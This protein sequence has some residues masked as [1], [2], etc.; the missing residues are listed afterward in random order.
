MSNSEWDF[1]SYWDPDMLDDYG[2]TVR[3]EA[4]PGDF[5]PDV[6]AT[7]ADYEAEDTSYTDLLDGLPAGYGVLT[8]ATE[9]ALRTVRYGTCRMSVPPRVGRGAALAVAAV[10]ALCASS[11]VGALATWPTSGPV[12]DALILVAVVGAAYAVGGLWAAWNNR[13]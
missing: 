10:G 12:S 4:V 1:A 13:R 8:D 11:A 6:I 9:G 2:A 7:W 3:F 5:P